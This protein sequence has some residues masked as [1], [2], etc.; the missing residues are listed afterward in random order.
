MTRAALKPGALTVSN[1]GLASTERTM[2]TTPAAAPELR[3]LGARPRYT[4]TRQ[5]VLDARLAAGLTQGE[6][7]ALMN[8]GERTWQQWE[9]D[10]RGMSQRD[11][12]FFVLLTSSG[13][14]RTALRKLS[15]GRR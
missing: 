2:R 9:G 14:A 3:A 1:Q 8:C 5:M 12:E 4:V 10:E 11:F 6:C 13:E 7:A 15:K